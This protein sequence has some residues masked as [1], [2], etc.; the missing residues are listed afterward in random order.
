M[1]NC[2]YC[3]KELSDTAVRC[4]YCRKVLPG[5]EGRG[6]GMEEKRVAEYEVAA[7][8]LVC[9]ICG[10]KSFWTRKSLL[11]T[12]WATFFKWDWANR[13]ATNYICNNCSYVM[14]FLPPESGNI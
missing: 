5:K 10:S 1:N 2:P 3:N 8:K 11:N 12:F 7:T 14:W 9:P 6:F 13:E 4:K